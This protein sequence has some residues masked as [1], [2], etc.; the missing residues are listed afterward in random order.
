[1][2]QHNPGKADEILALYSGASAHKTPF[3]VQ[4]Q[5]LTDAG[6]RK[7][8]I[9]QAEHKAA[10]GPAPTY[11]YIWEWATPA[12]DGK[13]GAVHGHDV[14]ASFHIARSSICGSGRAAGLA[15]CDRLAG[16]WVAF[17]TTGDP[18]H[19]GIPHWPAYDATTRATM[20]FNDET[21]VENDPRAAM[22]RYWA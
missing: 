20:M 4:A 14:D 17:A 18:S 19:D 1:L 15:M 10:L 22:R 3:L 13:F 11:M 12:Y 9:T 2:D 16:A 6:A 7:N 8:A 21:R 5:I